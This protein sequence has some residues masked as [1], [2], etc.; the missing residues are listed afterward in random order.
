MK[1]INF[2]CIEDDINIFLY[3]FLS[4]IVN[5]N[6]RVMIFSESPEK[7][8]K[9]DETLWTIKKTGFLPHLLSNEA[10]A[11]KTPIII[12]NT[13]TNK[14]NSNFIL[15]STFLDDAEFLNSF[16]RTFYIFSPI[17][18]T[19]L[20]EAKNSWNKYKDMSFA[21]KFLK[22]NFQGKWTQTNEFVEENSLI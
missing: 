22:K 7:M 14:N 8:A 19:S 11:D 2:Y 3:N 16:E 5:Q 17:S 10:G 4:E 21:T 9:L 1:E 13:K 15:I 6:K 12:S 20:M 18:K